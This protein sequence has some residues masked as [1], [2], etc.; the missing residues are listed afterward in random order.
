MIFNILL[1]NRLWAHTQLVKPLT[2]GFTSGHDGRV[3]GLS[4]PPG[5]MLS[6]E[7]A[8]ES[9]PFP[10]SPTL[11]LPHTHALKHVCMCARFF[12]QIINK[13]LQK[14]KFCIR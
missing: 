12:S 9:L 4:P 3:M 2:L 14:K 10:L 13:I 7:S 6:T 1:Q 5:S 11:F 8:W